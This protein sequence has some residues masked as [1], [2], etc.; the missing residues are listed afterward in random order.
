MSDQMNLLVWGALPYAVI[1]I[2]V[3]GHIW[4]Y[5]TAQYSWTTRS[6]QLL[7]RKWLM[8]GIL[9]FHF[10]MLA[11]VGGHIGGLLVPASFTEAVGITEHM[12]HVVAVVMGSLAGIAMTTGLMILAVRRVGNE[13]VRA[14]TITRDYVVMAI[15]I[16]VVITGMMN[17]FGVQLFNVLGEAPD[18]RET[19]SPWFR[20]ILMFQPDP[21]LMAEAGWSF[22]LHAASAMALFAI[23]PFTRL[24]HAWS[25]PIAYL[26]RPYIVFRRRDSVAR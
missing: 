19:V 5:Q 11:V 1:A 18:Y 22:R 17:T 6:S 7:E 20:S 21:E 26:S 10:G 12:Y 14:A 25:I 2:F 4:R 24:V 3:I 8:V 9:L 13:R 15:L 23:W 16:L